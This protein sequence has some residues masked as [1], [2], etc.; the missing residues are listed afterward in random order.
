VNPS[1]CDGAGSAGEGLRQDRERVQ[2][3]LRQPRK[4]LPHH[5]MKN[6]TPSGLPPE[7][8]MRARCAMDSIAHAYELRKNPIMVARSHRLNLPAP[9]EVG[10]VLRGARDCPLEDGES[11][12]PF[13]SGGRQV[14]SGTSE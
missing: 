13:N 6:G 9:S 2:S 11:S 14:D 1:G 3:F 5:M 10:A 4:V 8:S 12:T 7:P